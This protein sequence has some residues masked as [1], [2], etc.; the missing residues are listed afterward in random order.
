VK[1]QKDAF[2]RDYLNLENEGGIA[3]LDATQEFTPIT[4]TPTIT[5]WQQQKEFRESVM[6][7]YGISEKI[8]TSSYN[9]SEMEAFYEGRIEPF[10]IQLSQELTRKCFTDRERAFGAFVHYESNRLVFASLQ[11]KLGMVSLVDRGMMTPNEFRELFNMAPYPGGDEFIMRLDT[12]KTGDTT[13]PDEE[14]PK[15]GQ[16]E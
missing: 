10:L 15:E 4:M 14:E 8:M 16:N 1:K 11:T 3:S 5:S 12:A 7:Y 9:E 6:R 2:V 13:D